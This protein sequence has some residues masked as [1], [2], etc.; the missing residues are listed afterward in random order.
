M[1]ER[2][3]LNSKCQLLMFVKEYIWKERERRKNGIVS[4]NSFSVGINLSR[5]VGEVRIWRLRLDS[6]LLCVS[7]INQGKIYVLVF[8]KTM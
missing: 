6:R 3:E 7:T 1:E 8:R 4:V 5:E 2:S